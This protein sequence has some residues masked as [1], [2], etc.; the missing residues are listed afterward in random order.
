M[1]PDAPLAIA[2]TVAD[3]AARIT[4]P[5]ATLAVDEQRTDAVVAQAR[6]GAA[7][8]HGEIQAVVAHQAFPGREPQVAFGGLRDVTQRVVRQAIARGP[9]ING[10]VAQRRRPFL[11]SHRQREGQQQ[12]QQALSQ[13]STDI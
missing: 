13:P 6:A 7:V 11:R 2:A 5:Q 8:E 3:V 4:D 1:L 10:I 9:Y 12:A